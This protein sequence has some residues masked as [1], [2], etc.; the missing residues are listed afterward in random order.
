MSDTK[1]ALRYF[2]K[3]LKPYWKGITVVVLL[4]LVSSGAAVVA[5]T[6]LGKSVTSLT[7]YVTALKD[8][9]ANLNNFYTALFSMLVFYVL[10]MLSIFIAWMVM[11]KFNADS[12]NDMREH[13]FSKFQE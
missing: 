7:N 6:F 4:S 13:L 10:S 11:S 3:Y 9:N 5:P 1:K 12:T 8:G 2:V